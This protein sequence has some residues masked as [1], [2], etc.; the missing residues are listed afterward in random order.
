MPVFS[1]Q[2]IAGFWASEH[3][4]RFYSQTGPAPISFFASRSG[5]LHKQN[6]LFLSI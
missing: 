3:R 4:R 2:K 1:V 5:I 6:V